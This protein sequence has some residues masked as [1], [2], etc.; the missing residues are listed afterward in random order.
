M[1]SRPND[2]NQRIKRQLADTAGHIC[3]FPGCGVRTVGASRKVRGAVNNVGKASHIVAASPGGPRSNPTMAPAALRS[4]DNGIW[5]CSTCADKVDNDPTTYTVELLH[6]WKHAAEDRSRRSVGLPVAPATQSIHEQLTRQLSLLRDPAVGPGA[7]LSL[8]KLAKDNPEPEMCLTIRH[9]LCS[10]IKATTP[11]AWQNGAPT[12]IGPEGT[13]DQRVLR[14]FQVLSGSLLGRSASAP[15]AYHL[16]LMEC[17]LLRSRLT[18]G[19]LSGAWLSRSNLAFS[20]FSSTKFANTQL[21]EAMLVGARFGK[22]CDLDGACFAGSDLTEALFSS[23]SAVTAVFQ[24]AR[25]DRTTFDRTELAKASFRGGQLAGTTFQSCNIQRSTFA[26]A[27]LRQVRFVRCDLSDCDF[28]GATL[29][30]C[31]FGGTRLHGAKLER[32]TLLGCTFM[33]SVASPAT[34]WPGGFNPARSGI[35]IDEPAGSGS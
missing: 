24:Q 1:P 25:L 17:H 34:S 22:G 35:R 26:N 10:F 13:A 19:D 31:E 23:M 21:L 12:W 2:F 16:D 27:T 5:L 3:S 4:F 20:M 11:V 29:F 18:G 28:N 30:G 9:A 32:T 15:S 33:E 8:A 7:I 6:E 14:A